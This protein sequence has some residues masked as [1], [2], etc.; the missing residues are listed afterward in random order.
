[1]VGSALTL[2]AA[3]AA[4]IPARRILQLDVVAALRVE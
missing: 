4:Y 3:V 1:V 2:A